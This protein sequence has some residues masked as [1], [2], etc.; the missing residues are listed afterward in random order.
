MTVGAL[1]ALL[2]T[3]I[4]VALTELLAIDYLVSYAICFVM[5]N[6]FGFILNRRW[7]FALSDPAGRWEMARYYLIATFA[8]LIAMSASRLMV[9]LGLPYGPA[10]FLSA[11]VL[12]PINY[13]AHRVFSFRIGAEN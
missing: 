13:F 12:A 5:V 9:L 4:I 2:N 8:T 11:G 7:S 1:S 3:L 6:C 10:V